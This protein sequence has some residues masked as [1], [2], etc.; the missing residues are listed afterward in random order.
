MYDI[1][2]F[3]FICVPSLVMQC[4]ADLCVSDV[5]SCSYVSHHLSHTY[6]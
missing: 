1:S 3:V 2:G 6:V 5:T 4:V